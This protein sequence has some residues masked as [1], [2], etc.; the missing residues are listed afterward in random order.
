MIIFVYKVLFPQ[1][2]VNLTCSRAYNYTVQKLQ[3]YSDLEI[4]EV[5]LDV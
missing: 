4:G 1:G 2:L 5:V 3:I